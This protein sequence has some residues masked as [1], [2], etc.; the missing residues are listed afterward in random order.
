MASEPQV[1]R[2]E[3]RDTSLTLSA[4]E[5][6]AELGRLGQTYEAMQMAIDRSLAHL[7]EMQRSCGPSRRTR[8]SP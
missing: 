8:R 6:D 3:C 1:Q 7:R 5:A 4:Q 2:M